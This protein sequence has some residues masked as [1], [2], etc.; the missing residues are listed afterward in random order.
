MSRLVSTR[1][2]YEGPLRAALADGTAETTELLER[3][4]GRVP[5]G[6]SVRASAEGDRGAYRFEW[7]TI[8]EGA[9]LMM[10][11]PHLVRRLINSLTH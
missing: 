2:R 3:H 6:G 10:A 11:L 8:G 1:V 4:S 7:E 9:L 5:T